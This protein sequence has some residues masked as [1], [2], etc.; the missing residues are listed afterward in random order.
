MNTYAYTAVV[1]ESGYRVGRADKGIYGYTPMGQK[2]DSY[3]AAKEMADQLPAHWPKSASFSSYG[4]VQKKF[5]FH[6]MLAHA[7]ALSKQKIKIPKRWEK[8]TRGGSQ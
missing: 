7:E 4:A 3:K 2:F 1:E 6:D 8:Y 5:S